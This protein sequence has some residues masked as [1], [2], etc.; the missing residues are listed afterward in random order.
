MV[1]FS[2]TIE[3]A[4]FA[5]SLVLCQVSYKFRTSFVQVAHKFRIF[6]VRGAHSRPQ[7]LLFSSDE[8]RRDTHSTNAVLQRWA[9]DRPSERA[10]VSHPARQ[11]GHST[12]CPADRPFARQ[13]ARPTVRRTGRTDVG[14]TAPLVGWPAGRQSVRPKERASQP[15]DQPTER[16]SFGP[17]VRPFIGP[18]VRR[19]VRPS[20]HPS[21]RPSICCSIPSVRLFAR[22]P[23]AP[24]SGSV[25]TSLDSTGFV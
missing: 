9:T 22:P 19:S 2:K 17:S 5:V 25:R 14:P 16:Q 1:L 12:V 3:V 4:S 24:S 11:T 8:P 21:V 6:L 10:N 20:V 13:I 18:S 7:A 15:T 23:V